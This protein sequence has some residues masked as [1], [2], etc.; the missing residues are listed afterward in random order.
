MKI[1]ARSTLVVRGEN[2]LISN[3]DL[4][5]A[6]VVDVN[7]KEACTIDGLVVQNEGWVRSSDVENQ[8]EIIKM[9]GYRI[10]RNNQVLVNATS[11]KEGTEVSPIASMKSFDETDPEGAGCARQDDNCIIL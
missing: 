11:Q 3:L 10:V 9:R 6:L 4:S 1:S 2:V 5:G 7:D 8:K